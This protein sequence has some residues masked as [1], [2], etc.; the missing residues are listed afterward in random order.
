MR[1]CTLDLNSIEDYRRFLKIKALPTY[2]FTG[3]TAY[4]PDEYAAA[5]EG[6]A[7]KVSDDWKYDPWPG[8]FD[9]QRDI[10][11]LSLRKKKFSVFAD[12]GMGKTFIMLEFARNVRERIGGKR[13]LIVS[14]LMVCEQTMEESVKFLGSELGIEQVRASQLQSWM[15]GKGGIGITNYEAITE[16][17]DRGNVGALILDESSMLKSMY[18]AWGTRLIEIGRG[19]E[20]K[21]CCTG[22][23]APNDRIE[24]GNHA[25]FMDA[26]PNLNSFLARYFVNRGQTSERW[27]LKAHALKPFYRALSHWC[28]FL[29]N[30]A[31]YGWKDNV[32]DLPPIHIHIDRIDI[33]TGQ[34]HAMQD[35]T[36]N[37]IMM[38]AG[39]IGT[40]AK[41]ARIGKGF[42]KDSAI[43]SNKPEFMRQLCASFP[44][45]SA[46]IWCKFNDEQD[47]LHKMLPGSESI[48]G[49]TP[50]EER[51]RIIHDFKSGKCRILISKAKILG[52]GLNLQICTRMIFSGL[53]DSYEEYYQCIKRANRYGSTR[54]LNVHI[55]IT[56]LEEPMV[57]NVLTKAKR[58]ESDTREQEEL[59]MEI[60]KGN[61]C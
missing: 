60:W 50:I 3:R 4:Y 6:V 37:L 47:A 56:E 29:T 43:A 57:Q 18:G 24:Y 10:S 58:V 1:H 32:G 39:G 23:P 5:V 59:F 54:P 17:L 42:T 20:Y 35:M 21:L 40:R 2:S 45:E 34:R 51:Q 26:F 28:I 13:I 48:Q 7:A 15:N 46:I 31:V 41:L 61:K 55:P 11:A 8:Q 44:D 19:L 30:P 38:D 14:P 27:C 25:V 49:S 52:F 53:H 16:D 12:P 36:G 9:Y 22:T 33:T